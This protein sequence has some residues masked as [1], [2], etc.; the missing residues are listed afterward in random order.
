LKEYLAGRLREA[1]HLATDS[2]DRQHTPDSDYPDFVGKDG[3]DLPEIG[4]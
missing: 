3:E 1:G 4:D 2:G